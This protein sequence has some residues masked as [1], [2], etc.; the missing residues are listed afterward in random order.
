[1]CQGGTLFQK[2]EAINASGVR[3]GLNEAI[4]GS[5][6]QQICIAN[7]CRPTLVAAHCELTMSLIEGDKPVNIAGVY[8]G[9][10]GLN[11]ICNYLEK[12]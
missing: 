10:L 5:R 1:M 6:K 3:R 9:Q 8:K 2:R 4:P 7:G 12:E 11:P